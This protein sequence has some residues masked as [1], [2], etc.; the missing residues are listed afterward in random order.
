ME[1]E[2]RSQPYPCLLEGE[3]KSLRMKEIVSLRIL[4]G[5]S[6]KNI[7]GKLNL[8]PLRPRAAPIAPMGRHNRSGG[9]IFNGIVFGGDVGT[10]YMIFPLQS[11]HCEP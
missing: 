8:A 10:I 1:L 7:A 5:V 6:S 11:M 2:I 3:I 4:L 9:Q